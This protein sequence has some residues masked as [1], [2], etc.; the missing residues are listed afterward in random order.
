MFRRIL[1]ANRGEIAVRLVRACRDLGV[2]PVAVYS[3][4]DREA[5]HVRL[6]DRAFHIGDSAATDSYLKIDRLI[7]AARKGGCDAIHPG[8][9]FLA[10]NAEFAGACDGA[11]LVVIG[12]GPEAIELMGNK[13][14]AR[15]AVSR[16]GVPTVP[17]SEQPVESTDQALEAA[18]RIGFPVLV[19]A[20]AGGGGKGMRV[21][22]GESALAEALSIASAEAASAFADPAVYLEKYLERPRHIEVQVLGD[23]HN[24]LVHLGERECSI[25]RRHQKLVEECPSPLVDARLRAELGEAALAVARAAGYRNAGTVE[26]LVDRTGGGETPRY[27]FLEM[28]TRLQVEH[29]VTE[30]VT[31]L[32]LACWQIRIAAGERLSFDQADVEWRGSAIECRVYAEDPNLGFLPSPGPICGLIEPSGPGV[33]NDSGVY[34]GFVIP[35]EYDPLISKTIAHGR[36]RLEAIS[37]LHRAFGEY[38]ILGVKTTIPLFLRLL[39]HPAFR[40]G[41]LHTGFLAEHALTESP[42]QGDRQGE[43]LAVAVAA[44]EE[45]NGRRTAAEARKSVRRNRSAWKESARRH[46]L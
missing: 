4:A 27:Y 46:W 29:P 43:A 11:G 9:G 26:F 40:E 6:A 12:P 1:V 13:V 19:K 25:Q 10:E 35:V 3:T 17:G 5:L 30:L 21:V 16:V 14:A 39:V 7:D 8:Y 28:N 33:R 32:D 23:A 42:D 31:G 36:D 18:R 2:S 24:N 37:R 45:L 22:D 20:S 41:R 38:R 15:Q 34:E 44:L